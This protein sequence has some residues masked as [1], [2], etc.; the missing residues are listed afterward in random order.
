[1][2]KAQFMSSEESD[3]ENPSVEQD[4]SSSGSDTEQSPSRGKRN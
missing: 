3:T 1:M 4:T 2:L